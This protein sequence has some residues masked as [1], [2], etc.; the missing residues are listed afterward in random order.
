MLLMAAPAWYQMERLR[1]LVVGGASLRDSIVRDAIAAVACPKLPTSPLLRSSRCCSSNPH[2][3]PLLPSATS[4]PRTAC[5]STL[6]PRSAVA[7][8]C[9]RGGVGHEE[10]CIGHHRKI[11][12]LC[13]GLHKNY[14]SVRIPSSSNPVDCGAR[15][16]ERTWITWTWMPFMDTRN[17]ALSTNVCCSIH[18]I[19]VVVLNTQH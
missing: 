13:A 6:N 10:H 15:I 8:Q 11:Y 1:V 17:D 18:K 9:H 7:A 14:C 5:A 3:A 19:D 16:F 12:R 4:R 2:A